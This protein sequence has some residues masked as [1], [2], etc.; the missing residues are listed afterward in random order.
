MTCGCLL[1]VCMCVC[2]SGVVNL[3]SIE[4]FINKK[5][6]NVKIIEFF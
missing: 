5:K 3:H 1:H 6:L 4:S 2:V